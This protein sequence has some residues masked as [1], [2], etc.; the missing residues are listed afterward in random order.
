MNGTP[1]FSRQEKPAIVS[2]TLLKN[3][4]EIN[5]NASFSHQEKPAIVPRLTGHPGEAGFPLAELNF[6]LA[7]VK[8]PLAEVKF[9]LAEV[10][11]PLAE[12]KFLLAEIKFPLA[13]TKFLLGEV[14]FHLAEMKFP[15]PEL[16]FIFGSFF[17]NFL[18]DVL[19]TIPLTACGVL[20][21][22]IKRRHGWLC[23]RRCMAPWSVTIWGKRAE[24]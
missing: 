11:F 19:E 9:P 1:S 3:W 22:F 2:S 8:F 24:H 16:S 14:K 20:V 15:V 4:S 7:E 10:K 23:Q 12:V 5:E 17:D 13:E 6:P 18:S 21:V